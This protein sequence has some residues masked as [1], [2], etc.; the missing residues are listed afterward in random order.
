V[1]DESDDS[2]FEQ[3]EEEESDSEEEDGRQQLS[4]RAKWL[5]K[6]NVG[7]DK[8]KPAK[9]P[10][11]DKP[12]SQKE[13]AK[14][15]AKVEFIQPSWSAVDVM[16]EEE[17]N[18]KLAEIVSTRGRKVIEN[19]ENLRQMEVLSRV[20]RRFGPNKEIPTLMYLISMRLDCVRGIDDYL[21]HSQWNS[22]CRNI[23]RVLYLLQIHPYINLST[24]GSDDPTD[25]AFN[26]LKPDQLMSTMATTA[27]DQA[28]KMLRVVGSIESIVGRLADEY[29]KAVQQINPH[30]TEYVER[31]AD[32]AYLV[33]LLNRG[34][35]YYQR[36][37]D[38][39]SS[40]TIALMLVEHL[41]YKH[42]SQ[43]IL[44]EQAHAFHRKWGNV[45]DL[46]PASRSRIGNNDREVVA[47]AS[48]R[49]PASF[50][51]PPTAPKIDSIN[52]SQV[53]Q[54]LCTFIFKEAEEAV[55]K[56]RAL[57]CLV[58]H[59]ALHDRF[60]VARDLFLLSHVHDFVE[61]AETKTQI[62][63]NRSVAML[64][65]AAFR[66]GFYQKAHDLLSPLCSNNRWKELLAQGVQRV[67]TNDPSRD[68]AQE[69][70]ERRRQLPY[71]MHVNPDLLEAAHL[72][73][74]M[75]LELPVLAR[76]SNNSQTIN[77]LQH[78]GIVSKTLRKYLQ[79]YRRQPFV[80]PPETVREHILYATESILNG[81]WLQGVDRLLNSLD[82]WNFIP[83]GPSNVAKV[84]FLLQ[85]RLQ[86]EAIRVYLIQCA[87]SYENLSLS[88]L[89]QLFH[90]SQQRFEDDCSTPDNSI[91]IRKIVCRMIFHKELTASL[92]RIIL[93]NGQQEEIIVFQRQEFTAVQTIAA[94]AAEK[95]SHVEESSERVLDFIVG[96]L[97]NFKEGDWKAD[98][99]GI[100]KGGMAG[101]ALITTET[102]GNKSKGR[103]VTYKGPRPVI[104]NK[105]ATSRNNR[106]SNRGYNGRK[107]A[108]TNK[109]STTTDMVNK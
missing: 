107:N 30:T 96:G 71:H 33:E 29:Y 16:K 44:V 106:S 62:L 103:N 87:D 13:R 76:L 17:F 34:F 2:L 79:M 100:T 78:Q 104:G 49:H 77:L 75:I 61:K 65:L 101:S 60:F 51:G 80:G 21:D 26:M 99:K 18:K 93:G 109:D 1:E 74:A 38:N 67:N 57:L 10:F 45:S 5:K 86:E 11:D 70:E 90:Y 31:L 85:Q 55:L 54:E 25:L 88:Y 40:A 41:Y 19:K 46:H 47:D 14:P 69:K 72:I 36:L 28:R 7:K 39:R 89:C 27:E 53:L 97:Y 23:S 66:L 48:V 22:C 105:S 68:I 8:L 94:F 37:N 56:T 98:S 92:R 91:L 50:S 83:G 42:D 64:G 102:A 58:Y 59:H 95:L 3:G 52:Y 15:K 9:D 20:S 84:R 81:R 43:A 82:I 108:W 24:L 63:Y 12:R 73:C 6:P 35:A 32:E 4:G